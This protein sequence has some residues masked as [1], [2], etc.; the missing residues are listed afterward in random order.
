MTS[1]LGQSGRDARGLPRESS[2]LGCLGDLL[3]PREDEVGGI[4]PIRVLVVLGGLSSWV[5]AELNLP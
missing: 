1:F 2:R 5:P 3:P 4:R